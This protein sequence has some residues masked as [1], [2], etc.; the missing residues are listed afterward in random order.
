M[1]RASTSR[2]W[3]NQPALF[4][5]WPDLYDLAFQQSLNARFDTTVIRKFIPDLQRYLRDQCGRKLRRNFKMFLH[6][7]VFC[8]RDPNHHHRHCYAHQ[9]Q[10]EPQYAPQKLDLPFILPQ[11]FPPQRS[12]PIRRSQYLSIAYSAKPSE[13][14]LDRRNDSYLCPPRLKTVTREKSALRNW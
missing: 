12:M 4:S 11:S 7:V 8:S 5:F 14:P 3:S 9:N 6:A 13:T 2:L 10:L 1:H